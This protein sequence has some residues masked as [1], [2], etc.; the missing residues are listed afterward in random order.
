MFQLD[1]RSKPHPN[2]P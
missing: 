2:N 1:K